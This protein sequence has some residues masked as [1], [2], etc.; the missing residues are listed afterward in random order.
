MGLSDKKYVSL[1]QVSKRSAGRHSRNL[2]LATDC[3]RIVTLTV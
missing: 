1:F 3:C 2:I